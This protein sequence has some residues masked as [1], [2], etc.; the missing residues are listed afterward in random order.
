MC[1]LQRVYIGRMHYAVCVGV[2]KGLLMVSCT[3]FREDMK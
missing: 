2:Y 3:Y 1:V